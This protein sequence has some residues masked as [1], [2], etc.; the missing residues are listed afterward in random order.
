MPLEGRRERFKIDFFKNQFIKPAKAESAHMPWRKWREAM[1]ISRGW[2][3][4]PT[5]DNRTAFLRLPAPNQ[6]SFGACSWLRAVT[7]TCCRAHDHHR[8]QALVL[9][10]AFGNARISRAPHMGPEDPSNRKKYPSFLLMPNF[11]ILQDNSI[12]VSK[13]AF[14]SLSVQARPI[15]ETNNRRTLFNRN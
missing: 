3:I 5:S 1:R 14:S 12:L 7:C 8:F 15:A 4:L 6:P 13:M 2:P 9:I 10:F 11:R